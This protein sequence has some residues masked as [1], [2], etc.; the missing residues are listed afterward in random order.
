MCVTEKSAGQHSTYC[1]GAIINLELLE[2]CTEY[3]KHFIRT[4]FKR[5]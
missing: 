2:R 1:A 3:S 5:A 4:K